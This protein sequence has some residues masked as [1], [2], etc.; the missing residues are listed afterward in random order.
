MTLFN[1]VLQESESCCSAAS[2]PN[3]LVNS[4][5]YQKM[6]SIAG[7]GHGVMR[8]VIMY[9]LVALSGKNLDWSLQI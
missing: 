9:Y 7:L 8:H 3:S 5:V 6:M 2:C 1:V 4:V